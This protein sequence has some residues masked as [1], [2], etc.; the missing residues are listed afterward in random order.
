MVTQRVGDLD[1][2]VWQRVNPFALVPE[3]DHLSLTLLTVVA[4]LQADFVDAFSPLPGRTDL[5]QHHIE[6]GGGAQPTLS[7]T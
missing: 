6:R 7:F 5:V 4:K 3:G 2:E 1:Y